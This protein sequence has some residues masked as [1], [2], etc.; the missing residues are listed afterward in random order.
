M[1]RRRT[2]LLALAA[3]FVV[4][5][6]FLLSRYS[7]PI[8]TW[9]SYGLRTDLENYK[10]FRIS[11]VIVDDRGVALDDVV[12]GVYSSRKVKM[13][14]ESDVQS[15]HTTIDRTFHVEIS[16]RHSVQLTFTKVGYYSD[17][18]T[19]QGG[20]VHRNQRFVLRKKGA[21]TRPTRFRA[22]LTFSANGS[23][24]ALDFDG[25][26]TPPRQEGNAYLYPCTRPIQQLDDVR[27]L[28]RNSLYILAE[29]GPDGT[30]KT[31]ER[32]WPSDAPAVGRVDLYPVR[33]TLRTG[34]PDGGLVLFSPK[35]GEPERFQM[36]AA[37]MEGCQPELTIR[38]HELQTPGVVSGSPNWFYVHSGG[39]FGRGYFRSATVSPDR[40]AVQLH[41]VVLMQ[42]DG[43][44]NLEFE[45]S[46]E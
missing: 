10:D 9:I 45:P 8:A 23:G 29:T 31:E 14:F 46:S 42:S 32:E 11:G 13:G 36:F 41:V 19:F 26:P 35:L 40:K 33:L 18:R 43:T 39:K 15:E 27:L 30:I 7:T 5:T 4:P 38:Y 12:M 6:V 22:T 21:V 1:R 20:G 37:P 28:P 24:T 34:D 25:R 44:R 17:G 16:N 2:R 3:L